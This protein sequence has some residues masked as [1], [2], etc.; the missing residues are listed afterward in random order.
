MKKIIGNI[1]CGDRVF[2]GEVTYRD[3][4]IVSVSDYDRTTDALC[5]SVQDMSG[6]YIAPGFLDIHVHGGGGSDFMDGTEE[7]FITAAEMHAAH[8]TANLL[9]TSLT[10]TDDELFK[11]FEVYR[12]VIKK[13]YS[14]SHF[15]GMH[16]EGPYISPAQKGAQDE[17]YL[18]QPLPQ[19]FGEVLRRGKGIIRRWTVAPELEGATMLGNILK[20]NGI[21]ASMGHSDATAAQVRTAMENGYT[22]LTHFYSGMS[23]ITRKKGFRIAGML[24]AGYL[25]D[26]LSVEIICDGCHLPA[27]L[28]QTVYK[29]KGPAKTALITDAMRGAGSTSGQT[30]LGSREKGQVCVIEDGVAMLPTRDA[31]AGSIATADRLLKNAVTLMNAPLTDA[32]RMLTRTPAEMVGLGGSKGRLMPGFDADIT[33]FDADFMVHETV[34][35]GETLYK[36]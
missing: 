11:A 31:F 36:I 14:G 34:A 6:L 9:P 25:Y 22:L 21:C 1:I 8:G 10:C 35:D 30:I 24:E 32:V 16:L 23:S 19:H 7:D 15:C 33:I 2:F 12:S 18:K 26:E 17:S 20:Q 13:H 27:E 3:G 4:R 28:L 29:F 5:D